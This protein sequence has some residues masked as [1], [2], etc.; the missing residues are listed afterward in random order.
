MLAFALQAVGTILPALSDGVLPNL[1]AAELFGGTFVGI[2]SLTLALAGRHFPASLAKAMARITLGY[3]VTQIVAPAMTGYVAQATGSYRIAL[4]VTA[5][6]LTA[7]VL[8]LQIMTLAEK[9]RA[10]LP[11]AF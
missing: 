7:G 1:L 8:L 2:V 4:V 6:M 3:G 11:R 5:I 9:K 10:G